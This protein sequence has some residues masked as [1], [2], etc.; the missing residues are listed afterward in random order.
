MGTKSAEPRKGGAEVGSDSKAGCDGREIDRSGID[1]VEIDGGNVRDNE[2]GKKGR[3]MSKS[4][5]TVGSDFFT[6]RAKFVFTK[7][8]QAFVKA[9]ILYHF[10]LKCHIRVETDALGYTIGGVFNQLTSNNLGRWHPLAFFLQ[11]M[12]PAE[13]RYKTPDSELLAIVEVFKTWK[14]YLEG[15]Q[16]KV[17]VLT[18]HNNLCRFM[19]VKSLSS[20]QVC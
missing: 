17:L 5:K 6:S 19:D 8:R 11:K 20:R 1:N 4:K 13:T 16:Y 10:K 3:K 9:P 12:I 18:N 7:L 14:Y 2:V 15:S